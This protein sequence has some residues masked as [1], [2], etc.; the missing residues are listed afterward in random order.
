VEYDFPITGPWG[1]AGFFDAG[2]ASDSITT[3]MN[4][5][6]GVGLRYRTPIGAVRLDLA[7]PIDHPELG[8][9]RIHLSIGLAL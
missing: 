6:V 8:F 5:G 1:I 4:E 2:T 9:F 3:G 7:H